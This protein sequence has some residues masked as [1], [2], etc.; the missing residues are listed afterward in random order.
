MR[1]RT[2]EE[3]VAEALSFFGAAPVAPPSPPTDA[4]RGSAA[5]ESVAGDY[6]GYQ[7]TRSLRR[8]EIKALFVDQSGELS[9]EGMDGYGRSML[10]GRQAGEFIAWRI[11]Y[12]DGIGTY[13]NEGRSFEGIVWGSV[14]VGMSSL[15]AACGRPCWPAP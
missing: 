2:I 1:F 12:L 10:T 8:D 7:C 3:C 11:R 13:E 5:I 15:S 4:Y 14:I 9:G 6:I